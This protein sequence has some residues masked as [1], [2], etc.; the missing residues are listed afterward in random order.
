[1]MT[2][3]EAATLVGQLA[4]LKFFPS[5]EFARAALVRMLREMCATFEQGQW[6]IDRALEWYSEWPGPRELRVLYNYRFRSA[7]GL[8]LG[9]TAI[10]E[11]YPEGFPPDPTVERKEPLLLPP[12]GMTPAEIAEAKAEAEGIRR[13]LAQMKSF[14]EP[15]KPPEPTNPNYK[16]VTQADIDAAVQANREARARRELQP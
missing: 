15:P 4:M 10:S 6:L 2:Y 7:R 13:Q 1:M 16:P 12:P 11:T 14:P 3:E 8:D 9:P 5:D